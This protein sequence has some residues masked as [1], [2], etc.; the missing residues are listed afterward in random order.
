MAFEKLFNRAYTMLEFP[1]FVPREELDYNLEYAR[2]IREERWVPR[3]WE[4]M[5]ASQNNSR[6][7]EADRIAENGGLILEICA[8]PA[9]G[10][11][12]FV[13][14]ADYNAHI[15]LNDLCPT[16]LRE[17]KALF[18]S[19]DNPPPNVEYAAFDICDM[20]FMDESI[21]VVSG[22]SA[23]INI[24]GGDK[25]KALKEIHRILKPGGLFVFADQYVSGEYLHTM[26]PELQ[27]LFQE[28]YPDIFIDF[29]AE[30]EEVG[31]SHIETVVKGQWSNKDDDSTLADFTRQHGTELIFT[32]YAKYCTK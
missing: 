26:P 32:E 7:P 23:I 27:S 20:P 24:E 31:F 9:G 29:Q 1:Y 4:M 16:V 17:W 6:Q 25:G 18:D 12:P 11:M 10:F 2:M 21:D 14:K 15:L 5:M 8:G 22:Y 30:L 3:I 13:L 28:R 19:M